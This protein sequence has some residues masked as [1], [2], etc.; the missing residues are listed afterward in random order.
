MKDTPHLIGEDFE[1]WLI[2]R[3]NIKDLSDSIG[4]NWYLVK[5]NLTDSLEKHGFFVLSKRE[6]EMLKKECEKVKL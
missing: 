4:A 1:A 6:I 5:Y 2:E 3:K